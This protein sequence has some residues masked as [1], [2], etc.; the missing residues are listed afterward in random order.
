MYS[1]REPKSTYI[2]VVL[3]SSECPGCH[4]H[5]T[6]LSSYTLDKPVFYICWN[7]KRVFH[8]GRGEVQNERA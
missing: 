1:G 5:C 3:I 7:C 4:N 8:A 2:L 6:M